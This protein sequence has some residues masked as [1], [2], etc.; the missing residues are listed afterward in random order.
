MFYEVLKDLLENVSSKVV[1]VVPLPIGQPQTHNLSNSG[2][3]G[4]HVDLIV[5]V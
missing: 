1:K 5:V 2:S 4:I 3:K